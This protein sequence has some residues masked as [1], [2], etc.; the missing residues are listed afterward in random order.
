MCRCSCQ[1]LDSVWNHV[2]WNSQFCGVSTEWIYQQL[3]PHSA[4]A[5]HHGRAQWT[6]QPIM[7]VVLR[8]THHFTHA[9]SLD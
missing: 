3:Q 5:L 1:Q 9:V 8:P 4:R 7:A 2:Q 6:I